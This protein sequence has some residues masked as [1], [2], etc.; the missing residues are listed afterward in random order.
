MGRIR[1]YLNAAFSLD[2]TL[3]TRD[4]KQRKLLFTVTGLCVSFLTPFLASYMVTE[5]MSLL[6]I[7]IVFCVAG[8]LTMFVMIL[9]HKEVNPAML[10]CPTAAGILILDLYQR[11][12]LHN[13]WPALI[14]I[15]DF[16]LVMRVSR[17]HAVLFVWAAV[18]WLVINMFEASFRFGLFDA[19]LTVPQETRRESIA[20]WLDCDAVPCPSD[21][22]KVMG[23]GVMG[24]SVFVIDFVA[25]RGFAEAAQRE[26]A[27]M[28]HTIKTV[29]DISVL[30]ASY[31]IDTVRDTLAQQISESSSER[32][33]PQ[34]MHDA[35]TT[36]E[37][38]LRSYRPYLPEALFE[39]LYRKSEAQCVPNLVPPP[40]V[41][42]SC[43]TIAFTDVLASTSI[44]EAAPTGM[45]FVALSRPP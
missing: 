9:R 30:L 6:S 16:L 12:T 14:I 36:L 18:L 11:G 45:R 19:P 21:L 3:S 5:V 39:E 17:R 33:L 22:S 35:L 42:D 15:V 23:E 25:T 24:I 2:G 8:N 1:E 37:K 13:A 28:E 7:G 20:K 32:V 38:N 10:S 27:A 4:T 29:Q 34:R 41:H 40:G 44:W 31:D 26:Q 43:A